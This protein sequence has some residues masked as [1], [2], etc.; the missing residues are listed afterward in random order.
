MTRKNGQERCQHILI[1]KA[2]FK[3]DIKIGSQVSKQRE[4]FLLYRQV[5]DVTQVDI[6][7]QS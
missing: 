6:I 2:R 7:V 4:L 1:E 5:K 3:L